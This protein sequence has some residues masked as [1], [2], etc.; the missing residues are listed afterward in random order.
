MATIELHISHSPFAFIYALFRPG[1]R[2]DGGPLTKGVWGTQ[3]LEVA[4]G[5]HTVTVSYPWLFIPEAGV[6][7][8]DVDVGAD[9]TKKVTY[10][11][12]MIRY[13]PGKMTV[14]DG[15]PEARVVR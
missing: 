11:A 10:R 1:Y 14:E 13:L 7:T 2:I 12:G 9:Q 4:P 6:N 15:L 5:S 3:R 8:V